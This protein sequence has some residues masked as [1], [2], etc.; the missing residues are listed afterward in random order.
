MSE[1]LLIERTPPVLTVTINRGKANAIDAA[2]SR[3][4]GSV[5]ADFRDD[6]AFRV[7]I[8]TG[9]GD[10]FFS[11]GWDLKSA[12]EGEDYESDFGEGGFGGFAELENLFKPVICAVNGSAVGG[13]FEM[14]LAAHLVVAAEHAE[15][16]LPE[17]V[18][19]IVPDAGSLHLPRLL[20]RTQAMELLLT[21]RRLTA[22]QALAWGL[23]NQVVPGPEV[24]DAARSL[25]E[26]VVAAAPLAVAAVL[27]IVEK[28][29]GLTV[30]DG[31]ALLRSGA[32]KNY[33]DALV[34][35]DAREGPTAFV[36]KRLPRWQGR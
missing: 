19:G 11:A 27:E 20:S 4:L 8:L 32:I 18:R 16:F 5:F 31:Y 25:A 7:A 1:E 3:E 2:L 13:G 36:E 17:A 15:F 30:R 34:S 35:D 33:E 6:P 29:A 22:P 9:A 28:S 23:V 10:R 14:V 24:V 12:A 26:Q 21:G